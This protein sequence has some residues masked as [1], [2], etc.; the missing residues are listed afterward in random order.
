MGFDNRLASWLDTVSILTFPTILTRGLF[1]FVRANESFRVLEE[2][3][4][5]PQL[6]IHASWHLIPQE[7]AGVF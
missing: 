3:V 1:N 2:E 7:P 6:E 4:H 5:S